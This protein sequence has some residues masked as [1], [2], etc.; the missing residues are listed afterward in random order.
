MSLNDAFY[1]GVYRLPIEIGNKIFNYLMPSLGDHRKKMK[2]IRFEIYSNFK[3]DRMLEYIF[4][5]KVGSW[6]TDN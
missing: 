5:F 2:L 6:V 3:R 1:E 4:Q